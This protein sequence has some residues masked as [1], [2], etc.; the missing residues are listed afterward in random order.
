MGWRGRANDNQL[1]SDGAAF[2]PTTQRWRVLPRSPLSARMG[3]AAVWTGTEMIVWGGIDD[4]PGDTTGSGAA[5]N[6]A[7]NT[8]RVIAVS[9]LAARSGAIAVWTG[10]GMIVLGGDP[11][12]TVHDGGAV[13]GP[14]RGGRTFVDGASY[15]PATD[16]WQ[17]LATPTPLGGHPLVWDVAAQAGANQLLAWSQWSESHAAGPDATEESGG[18]DL[19]RLDE[20][21]GRWTDV[22]TAKRALPSIEQVMWTGSE[23]L[24]AGSPTTAACAP[25]RSFR[26]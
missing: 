21:T 18:A 14:G 10:T 1:R 7:L 17:K 11:S 12:T 13:S 23:A 2:N 3:Q 5:Y 22:A 6:P 26:R 8:W 9:P 19:F 20:T 15:D 4:L 16:R 25:G 24:A